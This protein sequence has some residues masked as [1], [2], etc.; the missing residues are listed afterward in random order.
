MRKTVPVLFALALA[1]CGSQ[2]PTHVGAA[3]APVA[4]VRTV[5]VR[6]CS[7]ALHVLGSSRRSYVGVAQ[8]GATAF[9]AP[10]GS[11]AVRFGPRNVNG[12][13]TVF[14]VLSVVRGRDC[15]ARWYRVQ[16]PVK[17][18]GATG[19]VRAKAL[20]VRVVAARIEVD[21]SARTLTLFRAGRPVLRAAV[22][23]GSPSTPT[24]IGRYYVNQRLIPSDTGGPFGPGAK[25]VTE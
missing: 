11:V 2:R 9:R 8:K 12:Y 14:G 15:T 20:D 17:P 3:H 21:L 13:P 23:V 16:L 24:P 25:V 19:Y 4:L 7:P 10:G 18:N 5:Q 1:G 6:H 22:A